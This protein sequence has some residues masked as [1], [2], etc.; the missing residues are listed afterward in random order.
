MMC[1]DSTVEVGCVRLGGEKK[2][3]IKKI[4]FFLYF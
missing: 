2:I 3:E 4:Q 1:I